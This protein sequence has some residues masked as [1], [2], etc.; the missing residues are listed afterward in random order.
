M[1][2]RNPRQLAGKAVVSLIP[3]NTKIAI[4]GDSRT[5]QNSSV[6]SGVENYGYLFWARFLSRQRVT[7]DHA[8]NYGV[9]GDTTTMMLARLAAVCASPCSVVV[10]LGSTNDRTASNP[11]MSA[12][13]SIANIDTIIRAV[14]AAKKCLIL[15]A[16]TPRGDST[17]TDKAL[18]GQALADHKAVRAWCLLQQGRPGVIVVDP[19]S[20]MADL[21]NAASGYAKTGLFHDGLHPAA[22]GAY[23]LGRPIAAALMC[24]FPSTPAILPL[25]NDPA[26]KWLNSN[27]LLTG[28]AGTPGTG[29]S[30]PMATGYSGANSSSAAA[31]TRTYSKLADGSQQVVI[32]GGVATGAASSLDLLR[33]TGLQAATAGRT[34][35]AV[36]EIE[37]APGSVNLMSVQLGFQITNADSTTSYIWDGDRYAGA[38]VLPPDQLKGVLCIPSFAVPAGIT[39][40]RL[41]LTAYGVD[42]AAVAAQIVIKSIGLK[43]V[44]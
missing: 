11:A 15:V 33:L 21:V 1:G 14:T 34:V 4:L 32:G 30:G 16:E 12:A 23:L 2:I 28:T 5:A 24:L 27:P 36:A 22:A 44:E 7:Y 25:S 18:T 40:F 19:W 17:Y 10:F 9:G 6:A 20:D 29:G 41:R 37:I 42:S 31:L 13:D 26:G 43:Y 38:S 3:Q 8:H 35:G 39:D